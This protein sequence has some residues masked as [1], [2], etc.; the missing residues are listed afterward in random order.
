MNELVWI[1]ERKD[2]G[3]LAH[4]IGDDALRGSVVRQLSQQN[5]QRRHE[6]WPLLDHSLK[7]TQR[8][9]VVRR[10]TLRL[11]RFEGRAAVQ[12]SG[13]CVLGLR[14]RVR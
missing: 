3:V 14:V 7:A 8:G 13:M 2:L 12:T 10:P 9:H 4:A 6:V 1:A 5:H 11:S